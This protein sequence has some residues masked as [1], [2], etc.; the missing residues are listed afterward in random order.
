MSYTTTAD[1]IFGQEQKK[2]RKRE[3]EKEAYNT[4]R[5]GKFY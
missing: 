3:R 5:V 2:K 4:S 1:N